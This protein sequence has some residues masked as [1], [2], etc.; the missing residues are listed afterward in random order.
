MKKICVFLGANPGNS[1]IYTEAARNLGQELAKRN[2]TTVYGGS[3]MGL[4][5]VLAESALAAGGRVTGV[6]PESL[7]RKEVAHNGLSELHVVSSMHERKSMMAKISDGFIA[8]PGGIGTLDEFFEIFTWAQLGFHGKPCGL[9][10]I[11]GYYD[12]MMDF[13]DS[14]VQAGFLKQVH[15]NMVILGSTPEEIL[16]SFSNYSPPSVTKWTE[17]ELKDKSLRH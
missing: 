13:L 10:N 16:D 12:K 2:I 6:I 4:M 5:G 8:L 7:V 14:V 17:K 11:G 15:K 3:N 1:E 9:L